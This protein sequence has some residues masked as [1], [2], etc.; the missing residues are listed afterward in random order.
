M[1]GKPTVRVE[2]VCC[3]CATL[4]YS[5]RS[6]QAKRRKCNFKMAINIGYVEHFLFPLHIV[7]LR[8]FKCHSS[9]VVSAGQN[10]F[11]KQS[12]RKS[13]CTLPLWLLQ[14][15]NWLLLIGSHR[16]GPDLTVP[17]KTPLTREHDAVHA[18]AAAITCKWLIA[19]PKRQP[20]TDGSI[21]AC[22]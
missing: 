9:S 8:R 2:P 10:S 13:V 6:R 21:L 4:G 18:S 17:Q 20:F 5:S 22:L 15:Q 14:S 3:I 1:R 19:F 12:R 7:E 16:Q 11:A